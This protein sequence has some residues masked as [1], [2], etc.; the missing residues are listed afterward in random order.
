MEVLEEGE[1]Q[2]DYGA[3]LEEEEIA[4]IKNDLK[5]GIEQSINNWINDR[6]FFVHLL[7]TAAVFLVSYYFLSYV[8]RDPLPFVDEIV[9]SAVLGALAWSRLKNQQYHSE[10]VIQKKLEME[11]YLNQVVFESSDFI[12]QM[13][14]YL[15][16]L[17]DMDSV[18]QKKLLESGAVPVFFTSEKRSLLKL[19][20][21]VELFKKRNRFKRKNKALPPEVKA[22]VKQVRDFMKYHSSMV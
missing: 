5:L 7:M 6:R 13:E 8:I 9:V 18:E 1:L 4:F 19:L 3:S 21:A 22:L 20:K 17:A 14:L 15:E 10:Q 12:K 2:V 11:Q 16:K